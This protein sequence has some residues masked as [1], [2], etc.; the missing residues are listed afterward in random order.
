[1]MEGAKSSLRF[2]R[3]SS[4]DD[5]RCSDRAPTD[6]LSQAMLNEKRRVY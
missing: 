2:D 4:V 5:T 3:E 1:M 6:D